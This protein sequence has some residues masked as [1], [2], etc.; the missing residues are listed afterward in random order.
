MRL[1][2]GIK[3]SR[4]PCQPAKLKKF[5]QNSV[6]EEDL[7]KAPF[8]STWSS[9]TGRCTSFALKA[10]ALLDARFPDLF[11]FQYYDIGRHRVAR[12]ANTGVLIDSSSVAGAVILK[13][14]QEWISIH[15][16]TGR[17]K[18]ADGV[19]IYERSPK[20]GKKSAVPIAPEKALGTCLKEVA[21]DATLIC[22]FRYYSPF[23]YDYRR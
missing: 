9:A 18:Y 2:T 15:G 5:D 11:R 1:L 6:T 16:L 22:L 19:L 10:A 21:K 4:Y 17:W 13:E 23:S 8:S 12:C 7:S 14:R 3:P 20:H